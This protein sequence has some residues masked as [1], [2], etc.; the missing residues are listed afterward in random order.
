MNSPSIGNSNRQLALN[1]S[2]SMGEACLASVERVF[3]TIM[4]CK[5][6]SA[7]QDNFHGQSALDAQLSIM[8]PILRSA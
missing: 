5:K 3:L 7:N 2:A 8:Q 6:F 4:A 1:Q